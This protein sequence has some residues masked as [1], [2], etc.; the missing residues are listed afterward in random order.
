[1]SFCFSSKCILIYEYL[2]ICTGKTRL[3]KTSII[4]YYYWTSNINTQCLNSYHQYYSFIVQHIL[5]ILCFLIIFSACFP[6]SA[7]RRGESAVWTNVRYP[8]TSQT[9]GWYFSFTADTVSSFA[10]E[11]CAESGSALTEGGTDWCWWM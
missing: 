1:M 3:M 6:C 2:D 11:V 7:V 5:I 10:C 8:S 4:D 9:A